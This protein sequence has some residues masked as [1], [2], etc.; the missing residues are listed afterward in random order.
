MTGMIPI[1]EQAALAAQAPTKVKII[2]KRLPSEAFF[3][4]LWDKNKKHILISLNQE[5]KGFRAAKADYKNVK[6]L[7]LGFIEIEI[8]SRLT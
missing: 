8:T 4:L 2:K 3:C 1:V 7:Y 6:R 5:Y